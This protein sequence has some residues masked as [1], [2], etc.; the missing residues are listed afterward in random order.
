MNDCPLDYSLCT[1]TV[2]LYRWEDGCVQKQVLTRCAFSVLQQQAVYTDGVQH[3]TA[4]LLIV[5]GAERSVLPGDR[6]LEGIGPDITP[7]QWDTFVPASVPGLCQVSFVQSCY[8]KDKICHIEA[9]HKQS[10]R[11]QL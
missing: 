2:T 8:W 3:T 1:Q 6:V 11:Q 5:P 7:E 4:F 10:L 9:G